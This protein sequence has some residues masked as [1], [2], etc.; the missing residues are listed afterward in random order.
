MVMGGLDLVTVKEILGHAS[1][2]M[3]L[4]YAH[5]SPRHR[6]EAAKLMD[7]YMDTSGKMA[8]KVVDVSSKKY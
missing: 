7:T 3:V 1:L 2:D 6:R 8:H 4:R 5:L